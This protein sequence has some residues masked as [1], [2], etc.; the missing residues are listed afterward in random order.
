V[1]EASKRGGIL[2]P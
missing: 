1:D 2:K